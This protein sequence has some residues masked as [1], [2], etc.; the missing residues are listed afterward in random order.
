[1]RWLP[2]NFR[3]EAIS[4]IPELPRLKGIQLRPGVVL[5][6]QS[7][8][9]DAFDDLTGLNVGLSFDVVFPLKGFNAIVGELGFMTQPSGG[10]E[11]ADVTWAPIFY[12]TVGYEIGG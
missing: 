7:T 9:G 2:R 4:F 3:W 1:M 8:T 5:A 12:I 11:D 6:Y 10:N